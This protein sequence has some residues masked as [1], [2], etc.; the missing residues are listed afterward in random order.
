[1]VRLHKNHNKDS[2]LKYL[3]ML[4]V[5]AKETHFTNNKLLQDFFL[6]ILKYLYNY[7][8][9]FSNILQRKLGSN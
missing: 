6:K 4:M 2:I 1:M 5:N 7:T 3:F 8:G 9:I